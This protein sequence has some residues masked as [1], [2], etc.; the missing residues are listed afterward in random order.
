MQDTVKNWLNEWLEVYVKPCRRENT[1]ECYKYIIRIILKLRPELS[2]LSLDEI[3][4][5]YIQ[6]LLNEA[7]TSYSKSTIKKISTIF[8]AAYNAALR[9]KKCS[10]NPATALKIPEASVKEVN[11][12]TKEEERIVIEAAKKDVLGDICLFFFATGIRA[13][14]L[15]NLKWDDYSKEKKEIYIRS[16]KTKKGIRMIPLTQE[17]IDIIERQ[18]HICEYVFTST[19]GRPVTKTVERKLYERLRKATGINNITNHVYRHT[20]ATRAVE[21]DMNTKALAAIMGHESEAFTLKQYTKAQDEFLHT[22]MDRMESPPTKKAI[23]VQLIRVRRH[24]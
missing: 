3:V 6:K 20:F 21:E 15:R 23:H 1:Y 5:M 14:E 4:E 13:G 11:P 24:K 7:A 16:S 9:N 12:L 10:G 18:P 17:A 19:K 8:R 2:N 22:Q